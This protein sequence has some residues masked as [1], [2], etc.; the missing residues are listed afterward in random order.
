MLNKDID[1][2][3]LFEDTTPKGLDID[4]SFFNQ[5]SIDKSEISFEGHSQ[6]E[7]NTNKTKAEIEIQRQESKIRE[8][9]RII[10][11]RA[12]NGQPF[13]LEKSHLNDAKSALDKAKAEYTKWCNTTPDK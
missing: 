6:E 10:E 2:D 11:Q 7:I 12:S 13:Y 3:E 1:F 5:E 4:N 9:E 8:H